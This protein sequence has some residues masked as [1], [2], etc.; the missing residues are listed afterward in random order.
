MSEF[1]GNLAARALGLSAVARPR[2][3]IFEARRAAPEPLALEPETVS[4]PQAGRADEAPRAPTRPRPT[5][6]AKKVESQ[7][8]KPVPSAEAEADAP[9]VRAF[10]AEPPAART[11]ARV[12]PPPGDR[13]TNAQPVTE[14]GV[15]VLPAAPPPERAEMPADT[16]IATTPSPRPT[17]A[18]SEPTL[19]VRPSVPGRVKR[20]TAGPTVRVT[21]G[22]IEVRA[23]KAEEPP[24]P[25]KKPRQAPRISL[26]DYLGRER[27]RTG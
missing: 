24:E 11:R 21:I 3:A 17:R 10:P 14:R 9:P 26:D 8:R 20:D 7:V 15:P 1:L 2:P 25:R 4:M 22:R 5:Q 6:P 27:E 19:A 23:V 12:A 16:A 18:A 13:P